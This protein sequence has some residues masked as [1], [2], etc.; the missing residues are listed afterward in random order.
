MYYLPFEKT[1]LKNNTNNT[2]HLDAT[3][4]IKWV[5][6]VKGIQLRAWHMESTQ[7]TLAVG[8]SFH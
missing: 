4:R 2:D 3:M 8:C 5:T 1:I 7:Q 6:G